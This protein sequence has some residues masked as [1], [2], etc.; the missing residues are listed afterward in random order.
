MKTDTL[1]AKRCV[2]FA[3]HRVVFASYFLSVVIKL[4]ML[5]ASTNFIDLEK[6]ISAAPITHK[7]YRFKAVDVNLH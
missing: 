5:Q 6:N 7:A 4:K 2:A 3:W 1:V